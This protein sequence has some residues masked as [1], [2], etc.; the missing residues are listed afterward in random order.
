MKMMKMM[1]GWMNEIRIRT[2][3]GSPFFRL[4]PVLG[5]SSAVSAAL[6]A[7]LRVV[8][9]TAFVLRT[10]VS[11]SFSA[12]AAAAPRLAAKYYCL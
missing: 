5:S 6:T 10:G 1:T 8:L 4:P 12:L 9:R 11:S 2:W 7:A 3:A